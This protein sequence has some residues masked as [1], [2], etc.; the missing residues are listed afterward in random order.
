M[1]FEYELRRADVER[2]AEPFFL[3]TINICKKV[4]QERRLGADNI[5]RLLLVGGPTM[6]PYLRERLADPQAGLGIR[7]EFG[8]DPLTVVARGAA[9]F[10]GSQ[11]L[12]QAGAVAAAPDELAIE[13]DYKP[14][15]PD[16]DFL[17]GGRVG[18]ADSGYQIEFINAEAQP[19][20]RSG[21]IAL[22]PNGAFVTTLWAEKGRQN[23]YAIELRDAGGALRKT[24]PNRFPYTVG[25]GGTEDPPLIHSVG[26]A[27]ANNQIDLCFEKGTPLPARKRIVRRQAFP[28]NRGSASD[29]IRIPVVEGNHKRAD[30]NKLIGHLQILATDPKI[31]R[32]V[33]AGAE[34]EIT[35]EIDKSRLVTTKAYIPRLDE[36]FKDVLKM[37]TG[38]PSLDGMGQQIERERRRLEVARDK[39]YET[40]DP[41][42][43]PA[44]ERIEDER[45]LQSVTRMLDAAQV[46][47]DAA[48]TCHNLLL[49]LR[50]AIDEL[51][52]ALET[53]GLVAEARNSLDYTDEVVAGYATDTEKRR[54]ELLKR[55]L[56]AA[57]DARPIDPGV[58]RRRTDEMERFR[59]RI[60]SAQPAY[61]SDYYYYLESHRDE[62]KDPERAEQLLAK[63]SR[64]LSANNFEELRS[65][66]RQLIQ[67]LPPSEREKLRG[68]FDA[69]I[70]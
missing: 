10:A 34:V 38:T 50:A 26:I 37:E 30:R 35:I 70:L 17:I 15:G 43:L 57:L 54:F 14:I 68:G 9:I 25:I 52:D 39:V 4:L 56:R 49:N 11:R 2:L 51:E 47:P 41:K 27:L 44:L 18:A 66:C 64:A 23:I 29:A 48:G 59:W 8:V 5:E 53:P 3:R 22:A 45:L 61:W 32:D 19:P 21:K 46:D 63:A 1:S 16:Q 62:M 67:L 28:L 58:L 24:A 69:T 13:L 20:W 40:G 31:K 36:E 60:L 33:P 65:A 7:L 55:D 6:M 12:E 42:A